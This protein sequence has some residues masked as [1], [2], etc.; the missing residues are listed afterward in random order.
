MVA[1]SNAQ[2]GETF[3]VGGGEMVSVRDV[4]AKLERI[5]GKKFTVR[6]EPARVGDQRHTFAD[7]SK[8]R[9][10]LGWEPKVGLD[11]GLA[12]QWEW[13]KKETAN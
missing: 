7:T 11:D 5:A 13:L 10:H 1:A 12:R 9:R 2:V 3:N 8:L 6:T 4:L